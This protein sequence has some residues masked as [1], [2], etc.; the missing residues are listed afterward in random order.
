MQPPI[1]CNQP[2]AV[3]QQRNWCN[4]NNPTNSGSAVAASNGCNGESTGSIDPV[5]EPNDIGWNSLTNGT[6]QQRCN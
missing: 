3:Y 6:T 5:V 2:Q 1:H 4:R